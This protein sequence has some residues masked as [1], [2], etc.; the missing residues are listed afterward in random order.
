V[1]WVARSSHFA[2]RPPILP[3]GGVTAE[4]Y[5]NDMA[6]IG[7]RLIELQILWDQVEDRSVYPF[8]ISAIASIETLDL[9]W[10]VTFFVG[11]NGSGKSTLLEAIAVGAGLN[12]EGGSRNLQFSTNATHSP[13]HAHLQLSWHGRHKRAFFL[14]AESFYNLAT[15][16][17]EVFRIGAPVPDLAEIHEQSHGESFLHAV[18]R[19]SGSNGLYL[20]DEPESALSVRGQLALLRHIHDGVKKGSQFLVSTHSPIL[21]AFPEAQIFQMTDEGP[22]SR[23]YRETDQYQLT[24]DFLQ[25]PDQFFRYLFSED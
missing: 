13:L 21:L 7:G 2:G 1:S 6:G 12:P 19:H 23:K 3:R 15:S 4:N 18:G 24:R 22:V 25:D 16:Y 20:F 5:A 14:R 11:E 10:P 8:N 17:A 9:D